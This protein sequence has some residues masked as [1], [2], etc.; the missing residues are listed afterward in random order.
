MPI[1]AIRLAD[2]LANIGVIV[3]WLIILPTFAFVRRNAVSV[4]AALFALRYAY[5]IIIIIGELVAGIAAADLWSAA[6]PV[7]AQF[8]AHGLAHLRVYRRVPIVTSTRGRR[9]ASSEMAS[10]V[11][12]RVASE[13]IVRVWIV[14][15]V[16]GALVGSGAAT[17]LARPFAERFAEIGPVF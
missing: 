2:R 17:V 1:D 7:H 16:A 15:T 8:R 5:E 10:L 13:G 9:G 12:G 3:Q 6:V 4:H 11:A 14:A